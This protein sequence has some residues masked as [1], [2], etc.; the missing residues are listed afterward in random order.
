LFAILS[1]SAS[2]SA[3]AVSSAGLKSGICTL[4]KG[5]TPPYGP[6]HLAINGFVVVSVVIAMFGWVAIIAVAANSTRLQIT[7]SRIS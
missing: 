3:I 2:C 7:K 6:S 5:G 4:S 1:I